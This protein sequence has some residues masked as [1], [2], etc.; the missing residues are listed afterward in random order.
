MPNP[1]ANPYNPRKPGYSVPAPTPSPTGPQGKQ[2]PYGDYTVNA[3]GSFTFGGIPG[4]PSS[5]H[6][7]LDYLDLVKG[8]NLPFDTSDF[9]KQMMDLY[10]Q[11]M[12]KS[13][14][15]YD[16]MLG[17]QGQLNDLLG[18]DPAAAYQE[19]LMAM[20]APIRHTNTMAHFVGY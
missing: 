7:G 11:Q 14:G 19:Q 20:Y 18:Q 13:Q 12:A 1:F 16:S 5:G 17:M 2:S 15:Y 10:A 9:Y 8:K 4:H 3:D 6:S